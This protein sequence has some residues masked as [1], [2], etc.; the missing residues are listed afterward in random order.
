MPFCVAAVAGTGGT[1]SN[2]ILALAGAGCLGVLVLVIMRRHS[3]TVWLIPIPALGVVFVLAFL[4][5]LGVD[6]VTADQ[7]T[8]SC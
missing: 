5:L 3:A 2:V 4:G 7:S 8:C 1:L 6:A